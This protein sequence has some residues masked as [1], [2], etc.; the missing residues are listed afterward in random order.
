MDDTDVE[1]LAP[2]A[3]TSIEIDESPF[4]LNASIEITYVLRDL[5]RTRAL[6]N[7][8]F[9]G[10]QD[11]LLTP[12]LAVDTGNSEIIFDCSG[13]DRINQQLLRAHQ[14]LFFS[15]QGKVKIRF[16]TGAARLVERQGKPAFAAPIPAQMLRLQ[17]R[18]FFRGLA[19]VARPVKCIFALGPKDAI[20]Y[21]E[22]RL[23]DISEGGVAVIAHPGE[24]PVRRGESYANT[25]IVLPDG[26]NV[27]VTL[28]V[29]HIADITLANDKQVQRIGCQFVHPSAAASA[30]VQRYLLKLERERVVRE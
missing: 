20:R 1:V 24:L 5:V 6:A 7:V 15:A 10:P 3:G 19:P 29:R 22:T 4:M 9:G 30:L 8:H 11:A 23:H 25:R 17:R 14:L 16:A 12:L 13:N 2:D 26:G 18:E 27:V 28:E 21:V